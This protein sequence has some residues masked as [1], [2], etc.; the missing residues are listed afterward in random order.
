MEG[1]ASWTVNPI[2]CWR[3]EKWPLEGETLDEM[4][5]RY[6]LHVVDGGRAKH[7]GAV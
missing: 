3:R 6:R 4:I 2:L 7:G 1:L 5:L